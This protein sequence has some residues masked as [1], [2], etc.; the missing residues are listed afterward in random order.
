MHAIEIE[1]AL[2]W[3]RSLN[4]TYV[5]SKAGMNTLVTIKLAS[6]PSLQGKAKALAT[7][8]KPF[9]NA[10]FKDGSKVMPPRGAG[11]VG[12]R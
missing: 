7:M 4:V 9:G 12:P 10:A 3:D 5:D 2:R 1:E 11:G 6:K 8:L